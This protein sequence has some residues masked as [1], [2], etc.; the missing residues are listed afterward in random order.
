M[1]AQDISLFQDF[2]Q[3]FK[4]W[5][6][7]LQFLDSKECLSHLIRYGLFQIV[8]QK[9]EYFQERNFYFSVMVVERLET[10]LPMILKKLKL[11]SVLLHVTDVIYQKELQIA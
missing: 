7:V 11:L 9:I 8:R 10:T 3:Y 5:E 4:I 2:E 6:L 1:L